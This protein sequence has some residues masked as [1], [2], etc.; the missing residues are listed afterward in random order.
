M[1]KTLTEQ[2]QLWMEAGATFADVRKRIDQ[3]L[4][5]NRKLGQKIDKDFEERYPPTI[6]PKTGFKDY[7]LTP[8]KKQTDQEREQTKSDRDRWRQRSAQL[9]RRETGARNEKLAKM[10]AREKG[11]AIGLAKKPSPLDKVLHT[12]QQKTRRP[13]EDA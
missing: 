9:R 8:V 4:K 6:N 11:S 12:I 7:P 2:Y 5:Q 1:P 3:D 13:W 10:T